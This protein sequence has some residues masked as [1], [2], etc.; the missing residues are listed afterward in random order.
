MSF[1]GAD[2]LRFPSSAEWLSFR[3]FAGENAI[4]T[5][6]AAASMVGQMT[7]FEKTPVRIIRAKL[8]D[9]GSIDVTVERLPE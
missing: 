1:D 5:E 8:V 7:R 4:F 2:V 3:V 9:D 6:E